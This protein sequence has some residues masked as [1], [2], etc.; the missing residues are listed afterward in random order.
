LD[1][2][3]WLQIN[4]EA[5]GEFIMESLQFTAILYLLYREWLPRAVAKHEAKVE[6][7]KKDQRNRMFSMVQR[8][9]KGD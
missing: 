2:L 8:R 7:A 3:Y 9:D 5:L 1:I 6:Q 4:G